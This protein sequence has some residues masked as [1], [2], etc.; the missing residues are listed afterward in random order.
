[1]K[2]VM[3]AWA[4]AVAVAGSSG[5]LRAHH[6]LVR[7]DT[8]VPLW[9][10]GTVV[11]FE[12]VNPHVRISLDQAESGRTRRWV[13]D[14]PPLNNLARMGI[15]A[16]FL[17]AGDIIEV[18]GFPLKE[19]PA[20]TSSDRAL[21]GHLLV[22]PNGKRQFWSDYGVLEKCLNAGESVEDLRRAAFGR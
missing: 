8:T 11:R 1:M 15:V 5:A 16:D 3:A 13:V 22:M 9:V 20:S 12:R 18:C 10:K 6:S 2:K 19:E 21:S 14:G 4:L 7:F 17:Q